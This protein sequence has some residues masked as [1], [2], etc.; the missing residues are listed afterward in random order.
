MSYYKEQ[1]K[2]F[3]LVR[4]YF[5]VFVLLI[6]GFLVLLVSWFTLGYRPFYTLLSKR[7]FTLAMSGKFPGNQ[8]I[9]MLEKSIRLSPDNCYARFNLA[10]IYYEEILGKNNTSMTYDNELVTNLLDEYETVI[11]KCPN[12]QAEYI[13]HF[14]LA[15]VYN[16]L[17]QDNLALEELQKFVTAKPMHLTIDAINLPIAYEIMTQIYIEKGDNFSAFETLLAQLNYEDDNYKDLEIITQIEQLVESDPSVLQFFTV[18]ELAGFGKY[19]SAISTRD[20][21]IQFLAEANDIPALY[22]LDYQKNSFEP[23]RLITVNEKVLSS[24]AVGSA[25]Q[26]IVAYQAN[27]AIFCSV[28]RNGR[29][30]TTI[31]DDVEYEFESLPGAGVRVRS[32]QMSLDNQD[33]IHL[34]WDNNLDQ[35]YY[36]SIR[37]SSVVKLEFVSNS[38]AFPDIKAADSVY[39]VYQTGIGIGSFPNDAG[40]VAF[41]E[42]INGNWSKPVQVSENDSWAGAATL[43]LA[44]KGSIH[45]VYISANS[46]DN[47]RVMYTTRNE[48]NVWSKPETI[49][50]AEYKPWIPDNF[51]GR[52]TPS[53]ATLSDGRL[54]V[55]WRVLDGEDTVLVGRIYNGGKWGA[56]TEVSKIAGKDYHDTPSII[57]KAGQQVDAIQLIWTDLEGNIFLRDVTSMFSK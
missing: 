50:E 34:V 13:S 41:V 39:I 7:E 45:V 46:P 52:T 30:R 8:N 4:F 36:A 26:L 6:L 2:I 3:A 14:R 5:P 9:I 23:N 53:I 49:G 47:A 20:N 43:A 27:N 37:N 16:K 10:N 42:Y 11:K 18:S 1:K 38:A 28:A 17:G 48:K 21:R 15:D 29:N 33:T 32:I 44:P 56:V 22:L 57:A 54:V 24:M 31:L 55:F 25:D 51:G 12:T 40:Q 35:L 19:I